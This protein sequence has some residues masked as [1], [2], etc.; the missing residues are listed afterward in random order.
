MII[1]R[2]LM[3]IRRAVQNDIPAIADTYKRLLTY[4]K[5]HGTFSH[6]KLNVYPT[7]EVPE[8]AVPE[9]T[10]YVLTDNEKLCASM[11]L[12]HEQ[13]PEYTEI[14]WKCDPEPEKVLVIHTLCIPPDLAGH[15]YGYQMVRFAEDTARRMGCLCIRIDTWLYNEPAKH[16]YKRCG[17]RTAGYGRILLHGL[18]DE[19]Q[20]YMEYCVPDEKR[21]AETQKKLF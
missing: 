2:M 7:I 21:K 19:D 15:G 12:D 20:I 17:F 6:W 8:K 3:Q 11:V 13:A 18:I 4:E 5:K 1:R 10:M 14:Q 9:G 16:L